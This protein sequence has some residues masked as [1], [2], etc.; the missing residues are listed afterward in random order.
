M[1]DTYVYVK[2]KLYLKQ[3]QTE[4]SIKSIIEDLDYS[5]F[6]EQIESYELMSDPLDIQIPNQ[7]ICNYENTKEDPCLSWY[8]RSY[9]DYLAKKGK[10][11]D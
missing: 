8:D 1:E 2:V 3:G 5:F 10:C 11:D 6:H 7:I 4:E 9:N